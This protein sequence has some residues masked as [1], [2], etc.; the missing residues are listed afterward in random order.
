M[1]WREI[2]VFLVLADE[3][4]F[5]QT[6]DRLYLSQARV[7]QTIRALE[8]R[9]GGRLFER[10]SRQ[11][12]LTLLGERLRDELRPGYDQI[13][14]AF[15]SARESTQGISGALRIGVVS[16][17]VG[18]PHL[19][20]ILQRFEAEHSLCTISVVDG[21]TSQC[22]DQVDDGRL[23]LAAVYLPLTRPGLTV[24]PVLARQERALLVPDDHPLARRG[25]ADAEDLT[26]VVLCQYPGVPEETLDVLV[27]PRTPSGQPTRRIVL[28]MFHGA[29]TLLSAVARGVICHPT[30][31][32]FAEVYQQPGVTGIPL[33]GLPPMES[34]LVWNASRESAI[35][36]AFA[37]CASETLETVE[38][39]AEG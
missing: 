14:R 27:P 3:L 4:H 35:I 19:T 34:A 1:E 17:L 28:D 8:S 25:F 18:G 15:A 24:G 5:G 39:P 21:S 22:L 2:E 23:D 33:R 11:V 10:T 6:A 32:R 16:L 12:S 20:G 38:G 37:K 7:S 31:A 9:V 13:L 30:V 36:R 26:D 29:V